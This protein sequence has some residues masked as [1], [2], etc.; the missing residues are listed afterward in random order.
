M[1]SLLKVMKHCTFLLLTPVESLTSFKYRERLPVQDASETFQGFTVCLISVHFFNEL[2]RMLS[3]WNDLIRSWKLFQIQVK[4]Y[5]RSDRVDLNIWGGSSATYVRIGS[6]SRS[7][8]GCCSCTEKNVNSQY[9]KYPSHQQQRAKMLHLPCEPILTGWIEIFPRSKRIFP[10]AKRG[11]G[12]FWFWQRMG[13]WWKTVQN[14]FEVIVQ[15]QRKKEDGRTKGQKGKLR[16]YIFIY[17]LL[18]CLLKKRIC[19]IR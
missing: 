15:Q 11:Q 10:I 17:T 4:P 12:P 7:V 2:D 14:S 6:C 16:S 13:T 9:E 1:S 5:A 18:T 8:S 19:L 3:I